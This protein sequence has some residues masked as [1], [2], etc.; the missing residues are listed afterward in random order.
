VYAIDVCLNKSLQTCPA[1]DDTRWIDDLRFGGEKL[2]VEIFAEM[3]ATEGVLWRERGRAGRLFP[4]GEEGKQG[5]CEGDSHGDTNILTVIHVKPDAS[6]IEIRRRVIRES[7]RLWV[8]LLCD[9]AEVAVNQQIRR[10]R[11]PQT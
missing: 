3:K 2:N 8:W 9:D 6:A 1:N 7:S 5:E 10:V 11:R 4:A